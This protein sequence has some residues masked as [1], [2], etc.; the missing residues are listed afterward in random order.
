[1]DFLSTPC[2]ENFI[3]I[4]VYTGLSVM[5]FSLL[6]YQWKLFFTKDLKQH[7]CMHILKSNINYFM[8]LK[9]KIWKIWL[10]ENFFTLNIHV[11]PYSALRYSKFLTT[12]FFSQCYKSELEITHVHCHLHMK[13]VLS[14]CISIV[15]DISRI[16]D[17]RK[18]LKWSRL[19]SATD[20]PRMFYPDS[21][22]YSRGSLPW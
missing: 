7:T 22:L 13:F 14:M 9:F 3:L 12:N 8:H 16:G 10:D 15:T 18:P 11:V 20:N 1:M 2:K 19:P 21:H 4:N 17:G 6:V 5:S